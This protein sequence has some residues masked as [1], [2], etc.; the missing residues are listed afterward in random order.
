MEDLLNQIFLQH[1]LATVSHPA[2]TAFAGAC[3][4]RLLP[5]YSEIYPEQKNN[6]FLE[7]AINQ[8]WDQLLEKS[9]ADLQD[10]L[11]KTEQIIRSEYQSSNPLCHYSQHIASS[12]AY[13]LRS[14]LTHS[15]SEP[16]WA[17]QCAN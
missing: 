7:F 10:S 13:T 16:I 14:A 4:L 2:Q 11:T 12:V 8:V 5:T 6:N 15:I 1:R 9:A 3:A 17:A